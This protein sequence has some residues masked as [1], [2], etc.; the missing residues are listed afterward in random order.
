[1]EE[2]LPAIGEEEHMLQDLE[3]TSREPDIQ[4][5]DEEQ[6]EEDNEKEDKYKEQRDKQE[7][8]QEKEKKK[9][10]SQTSRE[11]KTITISRKVV[12]LTGGICAC[13]LIACILLTYTLASSK[14][15][16][17]P[18]SEHHHHHVI[19]LLRNHTKPHKLHNLT[20][21]DPYL[22]LPTSVIPF[23]YDIDL[24]PFIWPNN[25]TFLG[26]VRILV[27]IDKITNNITFHAEESVK[28]KK[29]NV[30]VKLMNAGNG[31]RNPDEV[32]AKQEYDAKTQ[33]YVITFPKELHI[34]EMYEVRIKYE[35]VLDDFLQ[36]FYRSSYVEGNQTKWLA[37]TQFQP[38][39]AR[40]AFPCFDEP[41]LKA[42][43]KLR[44]A[45]PRNMTSLS[46]MPKKR[47]ID[48]VNG[49]PDFVWDVFEETVPMSTYL[50]AFVVS[51]F[52]SKTS[53]KFTVWTR[54][55]AARSA[56]YALQVG[57]KLLNFFESFF[58]IE[59]PLPKVDMI[60][61]PDFTAGAMENWGAITFRESAM[62]YEEGVSGRINKQRVATIICHELAHQWFGNLVTPKW[63]NLLWL[64]EG[65]AS[66]MEYLGVDAIEPKWKSMEQFVVHELQGV[67]LLDSLS[68]SHKIE[69]EVKN[70]EEINEI[71]DRISYG[72]GATILRMMD[73]FL[74]TAVFRAG[75]T[76]YLN[77]LSYGV[78]DQDD[79]WSF[80][81]EEAR[82]A[83]VF[84]NSTSVKEIMDTWTLQTGFPVVTVS[85][86]YV[87]PSIIFHQKKFE[88]EQSY[89][90]VDGDKNGEKKDDKKHQKFN[91]LWFIPITFTTSR[92]PKFN[93][94]RPFHWMRKNEEIV[95]DTEISNSEW[96]I[97][98][99]QQTGYYRV[100]Y[101]LR[102]WD[103]ISTYLSKSKNF[104]KIA[105]TNRAQLIDDALNLARGGYLNYTTALDVTKYL[106]HEHE[107]VPW[108]A[109]INSFNFID[110]MLIKGAD[111]Q[112]FRK[113]FLHLFENVYKEVGFDDRLD[114]DM[115]TGYKRV[116]ILT[117]AC[118]LGYQD[119]VDN[120][121]RIFHLWMME[122]NPEMNNPVS[123]NIRSVVYCAAI[124]YGDQAE[125]EFTW[126]RFK[127]TTVS[128]EQELLLTALGCTR[129]T[130]L[131]RRYLKMSL[132]EKSGIRK[133]D[134][135][136]VFIAV[137]GNV[138]GQPIAF[139]FLRSH[140]KQM[141]NYLGSSMGQLNSIVRYCTRRINDRYELEEF[142]KFHNSHIKENG[143]LIMQ[144][145]ENAEANI[146]W[147]DK[148]YNT[149]IEW[150]GNVT[151]Q[152]AS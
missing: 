76:N 107:Y 97:A 28:I 82:K 46:N 78:A 17:Q 146:A 112:L 151:Y 145:Y 138:L 12:Y 79:L 21:E 125:W 26:E 69:V 126:E 110:G 42:K 70:P 52:V 14:D 115:L 101:D 118:H 34:G 50:V 105:T 88:Y 119:C 134:V 89:I 5:A 59:Y 99:M 3:S 93:E 149:I 81:T 64:N 130:W 124:K 136:R 139:S 16:T 120:S 111:Y 31:S 65:F 72:K 45:R 6:D 41:A 84:D 9:M 71:F 23:A 33:L 113:Y 102:N 95:I 44:I 74:T 40:R 142:L 96:V 66:Y 114:G 133:H 80:F 117:A 128:S 51:D 108:K 58:G 22:R 116:D 56:D 75:L 39:D 94:T 53:G 92:A 11:Q 100:N 48:H 103:L 104:E 61:V 18:P 19:P 63:W 32:L 83:Q 15:E 135:F 30:R 87:N 8:K 13:V 132:D 1:M 2:K 60:A 140:W 91:D 73:H 37:A 24:I 129:E 4:K 90:E 55:E 35:G 127:K 131:L 143:R 25:F 121:R 106:V 20:K 57:P 144:A 152:S 36:G 123:P 49:L 47:E 147:M 62:L 141:K 54:R 150:L 10:P 86:D 122:G 67:F 43:F 85:R 98:N 38:T 27:S 7:K 77:K 68:S 109:A 29:E 137:S 148:N